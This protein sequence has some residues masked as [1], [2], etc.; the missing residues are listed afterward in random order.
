MRRIVSHPTIYS[1]RNGLFI[2][3]GVEG[4][5]IL[6]VSKQNLTDSPKRLCSIQVTPLM[7]GQFFLWPHLY[8]LLATSDSKKFV[9]SVKSQLKWP[10]LLLHLFDTNLKS[11]FIDSG[12][13]TE[14]N[15]TERNRTEQNRTEKS[16]AKQAKKNK[17]SKTKIKTKQ[18]KKFL[19]VAT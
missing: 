1:P 4:R 9:Y 19:E 16:K 17:Q 18:N 7:G 11:H 13:K 8:T 2:P 10:L 14:R 6:V 3:G 12:N 15:G 5:R